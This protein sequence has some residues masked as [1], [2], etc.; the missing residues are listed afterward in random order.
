[1]RTDIGVQNPVSYAIWPMIILAVII[2]GIIGYAIVNYFLNKKKK[3]RKPKPVGVRKP[4]LDI[5]V[6][7]RK[8]LDELESLRAE[9]TSE[10]IDLREGF[11]QMSSIIRHFVFEAT[12][13]QV[14]NYTLDEIRT[15][16]LPELEAFV[17][18]YYNP[19]F[20]KMSRGDFVESMS[21]TK[22]VIEQWK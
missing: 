5:S 6:L 7:K 19:E 4:P 15:A 20:A 18:E 22:R 1:M 9:F 13:I 8:Y 11:Q 14:Q 2:A 16:N 17:A 21:K 12:G 3:K 10:K